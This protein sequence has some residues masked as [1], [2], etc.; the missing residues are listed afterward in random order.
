RATDRLPLARSVDALGGYYRYSLYNVD[1]PLASEFYR[2]RRL[3]P[4]APLTGPAESPAALE[5]AGRIDGRP[6]PLRIAELAIRVGGG[7]READLPDDAPIREIRL[8]DERWDGPEE[9]LLEALG[10]RLARA[11]PDLLLT[12]G[13][14]R[15]DVPRLYARARAHGL[16]PDRFHLGRVPGGERPFRG[17][18]TF[19]SYGR[20][21]HRPAAYRAP[22]RFHVDRAT[23]FLYDDVGLAGLID[24]ARLSRLP[25]ETVAR[26]SP[27]TVFTALEIETVLDAGAAVP[28]KKNRPEGFRTGDHLVR[29]DRG[30]VI[31]QPPVGIH[32]AV[33][34]FDFVSLFPHLMVRHNLSS[35]TLGCRCCPASPH[36]AP[37]L[38]Y[39]FCARRPGLLPRTLTPLIARRRALRRSARRT[40]RSPEER[41]RDRGR[42]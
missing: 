41:A 13:G 40:D 6:V 2:A 28:W 1:R 14:D 17:A 5:P 31:F 29:A 32:D 10:E 7:P 35:E 33:D 37:G 26:Q 4:F 34:E 23:S 42:A 3:Y 24:A 15:F 16:G 20:I 36:V 27:G 22:G 30:G 19:A 8:G 38:G 11:D 18:H 21:D 25:F 12:D 39:R 9:S